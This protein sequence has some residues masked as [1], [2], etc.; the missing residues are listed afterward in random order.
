MWSRYTLAALALQSF[1]QKASA[2]VVAPRDVT[3]TRTVTRDSFN[4]STA[5][6]DT[7]TIVPTVLTSIIDGTTLFVESTITIDC[8]K[9]DAAASSK[10]ATLSQADQATTTEE[11][12]GSATT[13]A[14]DDDE[15][16]PT[17][18]DD[19]FDLTT[20]TPEGSA[21]S[22][23]LAEGT[24]SAA[25][26]SGNVTEVGATASSALAEETSSAASA[27]TP[28]SFSGNVTE[29][30]A[31]ASSTLA[32][33]TPSTASAT[34][35]FFGNVTEVGATASSALGEETTSTVL[36]D[37]TG[38]GS[39]AAA[40]SSSAAASSAAAEFTSKS[41][42]LSTGYTSVASTQ[43]GIFTNS[44]TGYALPTG[45]SGG[46]S[47]DGGIVI[48]QTVTRDGTVETEVSTVTETI[49]Q[50][51]IIII[52]QVTVFTFTY[53]IG[54][55]CPI[56]KPDSSNSGSYIVGEGSDAESH[57]EIGS[58]CNAACYKQFSSCTSAAGKN[59]DVQDCKDQ[60]S[61]CLGSAATHTTDTEASTVT[62]SVVLPPDATDGAE[63]SYITNGGVVIS[64][65]TL[66]VGEVCTVGTGGVSIVTVTNL[67]AETTASSAL[68]VATTESAVMVETTQGIT[69][70]Y[71]DEQ[72][73]TVTSITTLVITVPCT[74]C[75]A[76]TTTAVEGSQTGETVVLTEST[77]TLPATGTQTTGEISVVTL[78][79]TVSNG[80]AEESSVV[81]GSQTGETVVVTESTVTLPATGTQSTGEISV[82]TL[83]RTVPNGGGE[84]SSVVIGTETGETAIASATS[85]SS[86]EETSHISVVTLTNTVTNSNGDSTVVVSESTFTLPATGVETGPYGT[87]VQQTKS[88]QSTAIA[89][90]ETGQTVAESTGTAITIPASVGTTAS[91]ALAGATSVGGS[92]TG[93]TGDVTTSLITMSA[94]GTTSIY[95]MTL[96]GSY[97]AGSGTGVYEVPGTVATSEAAAETETDV[98]G[99]QTGA[100]GTFSTSYVTMTVSPTCGGC[101][102]E[103][104]VITVTVDS[105]AGATESS[106]L[107]GTATRLV[108]TQYVTVTMGGSTGVISMTLTGPGAAETVTVGGGDKTV[109]VDGGK[110]STVYITAGSDKTVTV[111][112]K[113]E[114]VYQ[115]GGQ[116]TTI[117]ETGVKTATITKTGEASTVTI[118]RD[119]ENG[120][121]SVRGETASGSGETATGGDVKTVTVI[122]GGGSETAVAVTVTE[123]E[124]SVQTITSCPVSDAAAATTLATATS[125]A[126]ATVYVT[127][128]VNQRA[129][130]TAASKWRRLIGF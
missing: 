27:S 18:T 112:G 55:N 66:T 73:S 114:T 110:A 44:S 51:V 41:I 115:T 32:D 100:G 50:P 71:V 80:G 56:V 129:E 23:A 47:G 68:G 122:G 74:K 22:S 5:V 94:S 89:G 126:P 101:S 43:A 42:I 119:C 76:G 125:K 85:S 38:A 72:G 113:T 118:T 40:A 124:T 19:D 106:A 61:A 117:F 91:S 83:T 46:E 88:I 123:T 15:E 78:T 65:V 60:L 1:A 92:L 12:S 75:A 14:D 49:S 79:R 30:G 67:P 59:F 7:E 10:T 128:T 45:T 58:A 53:A 33:G 130:N 93:V 4:G 87:G 95:T 29:V 104:T 84:E 16:C 36:G 98:V 90:T 121:C 77:V 34:S 35:S 69:V 62:Q 70:S 109:T 82:V 21:A 11:S 31:T 64:T 17:D 3:L 116:T 24:S 6:V 107:A 57:T 120:N 20:A 25:S 108:S 63:S 81:T 39:S 103:E 127:Q 54:A 13:A 26:F 102:A 111:G 96:S 8:T 9:C 2:G 105:P 28:A 86:G 52:R 97:P 99:T 37:A 48:T